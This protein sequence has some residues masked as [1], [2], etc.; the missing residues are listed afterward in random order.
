MKILVSGATGYIGSNLVNKLI[1]E[2][3]EVHVL[4][5]KD[6]NYCLIASKIKE[7]NIHV[8]TQDIQ[9]LND[10]FNEVRPT[11]VIHL[12]SLFKVNH[13]KEDVERLI[14]SNILFGAQLLEVSVLC[15]VKYFLN[16][17]T[18]WQHYLG[19]D[20]NPVNLYAATKEA[21]EKIAKFYLETSDLRI[22]TLKLMDTYGPRD[23]R[24]KILNLI[25]DASQTNKILEMSGGEQELG[26][27]YIDDVIKAYKKAL[28]ELVAM[29]AHEE[30]TY[31]V[32]PK[33]YLTLKNV[34]KIFEEVSNRKLNV[35][36][37]KRPYRTR[38]IMKIQC[39]EKN[40]LANEEI[41]NLKDGLAKMLEIDR[42]E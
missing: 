40:I 14:S 12:A 36:W 20:Y 32:S 13:E 24:G 29:K 22:I 7:K 42:E 5:R 38:E 27:V 16:T 30:K 17:G 9:N 11:V 8:Y 1:E 10:I 39:K 31:I 28:K 23:S 3:N 34:V 25:K 21:F 4:V 35:Y 2:G 33:E 37:G 41:L 15:G 18:Y 6:S 19:E 26:L